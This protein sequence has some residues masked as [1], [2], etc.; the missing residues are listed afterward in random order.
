MS[1]SLYERTH[2]ARSHRGERGWSEFIYRHNSP[3]PDRSQKRRSIRALI[4]LEFFSNLCDTQA[5]TSPPAIFHP[6]C[7]VYPT[8][9]PFPAFPYRAR[10]YTPLPRQPRASPTTSLS[11][12]T[13]H[14]IN[15]RLI[16]LQCDRRD[17]GWSII[18][19][20]QPSLCRSE[21]KIPIGTTAEPSEAS[22]KAK[23]Q[24][25]RVSAGTLGCLRMSHGRA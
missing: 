10:V 19:L 24:K 17:L 15:I 8:P 14:S 11:K 21:H 6:P 18:L 5:A 23:Q 7:P 1:F 9:P 4:S 16:L 20:S 22:P 13:L 12:Y 2:E 3:L 25:S